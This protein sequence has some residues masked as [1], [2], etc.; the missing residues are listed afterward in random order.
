MVWLLRFNSC[1]KEGDLN[2]LKFK[3]IKRFM[4]HLSWVDGGFN[5]GEHEAYLKM[6]KWLV[7][8]TLSMLVLK[9]KD[10]IPLMRPLTGDIPL[11]CYCTALKMPLN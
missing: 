11:Y 3:Q 7:M 6:R 4:I 5:Q 9:V 2:V 8:E 1:I 10:S